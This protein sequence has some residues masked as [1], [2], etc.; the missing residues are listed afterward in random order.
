M[1]D[2]RIIELYFARD[3]RAIEETKLKY[4]RLLLS[5][6]DSILSDRSLAEECE[7]DTY[8][9][10]WNSI[11][12]TRPTYFSAYLTRIA[13]NF[14]LNR[15]RGNRRNSTPEMNLILDVRQQESSQPPKPVRS[16]YEPPAR[17]SRPA[18]PPNHPLTIHRREHLDMQS[19]HSPYSKHWNLGLTCFPVFGMRLWPQLAAGRWCPTPATAP[20]PCNRHLSQVAA[21][22]SRSPRPPT[23]PPMRSSLRFALIRPLTGRRRQ[24]LRRC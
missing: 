11:P 23:L 3:E 18:P 10:A 2:S 16:L 24:L 19:C 7:S 5:V 1:E 12:P 22:M 15:L 4:S 20:P 9:R 17:L 8:L 14:A 13:R 6:A 21:A